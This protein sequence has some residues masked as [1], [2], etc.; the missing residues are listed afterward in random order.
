MKS[1]LLGIN[2]G[3]GIGVLFLT[4]SLIT[5]LLVFSFYFDKN[6]TKI[7]AQTLGN[8][9]FY[10]NLNVGST[11]EDV[12]T[13]QRVLNTDPRTQVSQSGYGSPELETTG[14]GE[15]TKKAVQTFQSLND[16]NLYPDGTLII[17]SG[18]VDGET[19]IKLNNYAAS[20]GFG[21]NLNAGLNNSLPPYIPGVLQ[22][23][24]FNPSDSLEVR[25]LNGTYKAGISVIPS[26][27]FI[28]SITPNK[29]KNGDT[30]TIRGRNFSTSTSNIIYM[31]YDKITATSTDGTTINVLVKSSLND[32]FDKQ[33]EDL[34]DD[35]RKEVVG[36]IPNIPLF[37][38]VQNDKSISYP[39]LIHFNIK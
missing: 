8:G 12:K 30:I 29:V 5:S 16:E 39:Y 17:Y 18:A 27:P 24:N 26:F 21:G 23:N 3:I 10:R 9:P 36:M 32:L 7:E 22:Q 4:L 28:D 35:E 31:S 14:F 37:I 38:M 15:L 13:L 11:G 2:I 6:Q 33:T 1:R 34:D 25:Q 20:R 19:R